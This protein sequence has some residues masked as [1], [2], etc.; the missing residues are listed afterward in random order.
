MDNKGFISVEFLFSLFIILIV[1]TGLLVYSQN[2]INSTL[3]VESDLNHRLILDNVANTINQ[4]D[5]QGEFYSKYLKLPVTDK[6]YVLTLNKNKL[7]IE[8]D[9]KKGEMSVPFIDSYSSYKMYPGRIYV[10]EKT[11]EGKILIK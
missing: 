10:I 8:Y 1:A 11:H 7:I 9:N 5:S 6:N 4:V 3:N 2:T